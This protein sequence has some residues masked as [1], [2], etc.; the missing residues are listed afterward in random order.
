MKYRG[1]LAVLGL[2]ISISLVS[3][4]GACE[5]KSKMLGIVGYNYTHRYIDSFDVE[6]QGGGNIYLSTATSGGGGTSC[7]IGYNPRLKLPIQMRVRWT[8]GYKRDAKGKIV[9]PNETHETI[10][11]LHGPVP[12]D[13][14]QLEVHFMPD[15][16]VQLR[17]TRE[18][19]LP[20]LIIDRNKN[21]AP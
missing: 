9:L 2:G 14:Q 1:L 15:G 5:E 20:M 6:G 11:E 18:Y 13:P 4:P 8:F 17:I 21:K 12:N 16:T 19:S 3:A 10:A 7:C